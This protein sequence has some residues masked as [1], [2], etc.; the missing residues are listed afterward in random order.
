MLIDSQPAIVVPRV[1]VIIPTYNAGSDF[2]GLLERLQ[3]QTLAPHEIIV[4]DSSSTD[5]TAERSQRAGVRVFSI[6]QSEFDHGG[7][8]NYAA[9]LAEG[10]VLVFMTQDA[11]PDNDFMLEELVKPFQDGKIS[12]VY[13]RQLAR[14]DANVLERL[15]RGFN[16]PEQSS[17][18][19]QGDIPRMGIKTFF[20]SNVCAAVRKDIFLELGRFPEP[21]I[22]NEDLFFAAKCI[23]QGYTVAYAAEARVVH[24]H[25]Y[26]LI[27]QFRRFFD[28]GVSMRNNDWVFQ[29]SAVGKEGSRLVKT[30]LNALHRQRKWHWMPRLFAE[31]AAKLFGYQLGKRYRSLPQGLCIRFSMHRKIWD[32]LNATA[33]AKGKGMSI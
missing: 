12:C 27:Q 17:V 4:V 2:G 29:Y 30:Q 15:S 14:P 5:G 24:S 18:K 7:T 25:D 8:R 6:L 28:N 19:D 31:S 33:A 22:F 32:K 16:Y 3:Q 11:I 23:L 9:G 1:S 20:C 26:T 21:V 10:D 13:G